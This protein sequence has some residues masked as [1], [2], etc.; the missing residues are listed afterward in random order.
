MKLVIAIITAD[1]LEAVER[2]VHEAEAA[3]ICTAEVN[4][5]VKRHTA[6]Y[7]GTPYLAS[8]ALLRLDI[9]IVNEMLVE[10]AV[11]AILRA[12]SDAVNVFVLPLDDW[13]SGRGR[14]MEQKSALTAAVPVPCLNW[15]TPAPMPV[16][17]GD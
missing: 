11:N 12:C 6:F 4:D 2:A 10:E 3:V 7:R 14:V 16:G 9:V 13:I 15:S 8:R 5:M 1:D 17:P